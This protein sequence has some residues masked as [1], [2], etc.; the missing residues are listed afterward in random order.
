M[1]KHRKKIPTTTSDELLY[2]FDRTCC[3]CQDPNKGTQIHHLDG[4]P[5]NNEPENLAVLCLQCH[6]DATKKGG[7]TKS[8]S[9][10]LIR[11]YREYWLQRVQHKRLIAADIDPVK[12]KAEEGVETFIDLLRS[13][14]VD[15][16]VDWSPENEPEFSEVDRDQAIR[17]K[18]SLHLAAKPAL[19]HGNT[20]SLGEA[21]HVI[22]AGYKALILELT[23]FYPEGHFGRN[24][25]E[26]YLERFIEFL[27]D[28]TFL[29]ATPTHGW[30]GTMHANDCGFRL[31][32]MLD[33]IAK[34]MI[35]TL[36]GHH[37]AE[38][39]EVGQES[40]WLKAWKAAEK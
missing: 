16:T 11:K 3:V 24:G 19:E 29:S 39:E 40:E 37:L 18:R 15:D 6:D 13:G 14:S 21:A 32:R 10:G 2:L 28:W 23:E 27:A 30:M 31:C 1:A 38:W 33:D 34:D 26:E 7:F 25:A 8:L 35:R 9:V 22:S 20:I 12:G 36:S 4:D 17:R 5:A